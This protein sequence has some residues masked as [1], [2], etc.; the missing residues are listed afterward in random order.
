MYRSWYF[1]HVLSTVERGEGGK[2]QKKMERNALGQS[3]IDG[4]KVHRLRRAKGS[5]VI[6]AVKVYSAERSCAE[7]VV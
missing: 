7:G 4:D 2:K 6:K 3:A 1:P 5:K